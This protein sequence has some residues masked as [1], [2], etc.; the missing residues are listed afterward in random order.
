MNKKKAIKVN[1]SEIIK[2]GKLLTTKK[3]PISH[4]DAKGKV[5]IKHTGRY[6]EVTKDAIGKVH[7]LVD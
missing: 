6:N 7:K 3:D 4:V 1:K 5:Y 2:K